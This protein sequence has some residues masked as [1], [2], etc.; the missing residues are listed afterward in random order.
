[1]VENRQ[2]GITKAYRNNK[3]DFDTSTQPNSSVC[4]SVC[5]KISF[6]Y[7]AENLLIRDLWWYSEKIKGP[8]NLVKN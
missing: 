3:K 2:K 6:N 8:T 4:E 5:G 7:S 1:M